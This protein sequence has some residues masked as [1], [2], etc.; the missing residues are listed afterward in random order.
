MKTFNI[1]CKGTWGKIIIIWLCSCWPN[2]RAFG[3]IQDRRHQNVI[4]VRGCAVKKAIS[5][6]GASERDSRTLCCTPLSKTDSSKNS[7]WQRLKRI[8]SSLNIKLYLEAREDK[9]DTNFKEKISSGVWFF[10][11]EISSSTNECLGSWSNLLETQWNLLT[12]K[13]CEVGLDFNCLLNWIFILFFLKKLHYLEPK[14]KS[15]VLPLEANMRSGKLCQENPAQSVSIYSCKLS[16]TKTDL[17][18]QDT[19]LKYK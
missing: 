8:Y 6:F 12:T 9:N 18:F 14:S 1:F 5:H 7:I 10:G 16:L 4:H 17:W 3:S 2:I 11:M 19:N 15:I 13:V